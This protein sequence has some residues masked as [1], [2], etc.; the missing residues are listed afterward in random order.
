M[1]MMGSQPVAGGGLG[2][3]VQARQQLRQL[4]GQQPLPLEGDEVSS[5][6]P[7]Q[8]TLVDGTATSQPAARWEPTTAKNAPAEPVKALQKPVKSASNATQT[9]SGLRALFD[10]IKAVARQVGFIEPS[11]ADIQRAFQYNRQLLVDYKV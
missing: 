9:P 4:Q 10:D 3:F 8:K 2:G 6:N 5:S 11:D 7:K 1:M